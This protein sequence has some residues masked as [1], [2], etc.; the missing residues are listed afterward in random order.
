VMFSLGIVD[1]DVPVGCEVTLVWGEERGGSGK[2]TVESHRQY[3]I[4]AIVSPAPYSAVVR[5][6]YAPGWRTTAA[7]T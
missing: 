5:E 1:P 7:V 3:E 2:T 4:R 6:S